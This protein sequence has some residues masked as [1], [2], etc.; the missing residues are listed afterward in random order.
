[1]GIFKNKKKPKS[2]DGIYK[3]NSP[4]RLFNYMKDNAQ[5]GYVNKDGDAILYDVNPKDYRVQSPLD[6]Y[7]TMVGTCWD[8][9]LFEK[10]I[11]DTVI[12]NECKLY[13]I[14]QDNL[15]CTTHTFIIFKYRNK[16]YYME[17]AFERIK[18]MYYFKTKEEI[19]DFVIS[20]M[21]KDN[22]DNGVEVYEIN[23]DYNTYSKNY[24]TK[25]DCSSFMSFCESCELV[26]KS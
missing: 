5:Y 26:Y 24:T 4:E 9:A 7:N 20:E 15:N 1:M 22:V 2:I 17:N 23:K 6:F 19:F 18:G 25:T 11:F 12:R 3:L 10:F 8:Q 14:V 21:R 16:F 13:Y